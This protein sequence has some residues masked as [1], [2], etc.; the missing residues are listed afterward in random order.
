[1]PAPPMASDMVEDLRA[2][3]RALD[4]AAPALLVG[5]SLSALMVQFYACKF[6]SEVS[7]LLL[8]DPTPDAAFAG[9]DRHPQPVQHHIRQVMLKNAAH[10]GLSE[11]GLAEFHYLPE[12][13]SELLSAMS[14]DAPA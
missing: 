14:G 9:F 12:S 7:A 5:W 11:Q 1:A 8:L 10:L 6:P 13:C 4:L 3:L 2:L